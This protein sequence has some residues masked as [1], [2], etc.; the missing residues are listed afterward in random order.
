[1]IGP[2]CPDRHI[3]PGILHTEGRVDVLGESSA[4]RQ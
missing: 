4:T 2:F 3:D 1:M